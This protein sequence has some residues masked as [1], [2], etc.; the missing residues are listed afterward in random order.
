MEIIVVISIILILFMMILPLWNHLSSKRQNLSCVQ[1]LRALGMAGLS[2]AAENDGALVPY[3]LV[4]PYGDGFWYKILWP[5]LGFTETFHF[6]KV[7]DRKDVGPF[8]CPLNKD[9][10]YA[11]N[12]IC[13]WNNDSPPTANGFKSYL[14]MGQGIVES[15]QDT[16]FGTLYKWQPYILPGSPYETAWFSDGSQ[17]L[18]PDRPAN[19]FFLS[20]HHDGYANVVYM[21]GSVRRVKDPDFAAHPDIIRTSREWTFFFGRPGR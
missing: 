2:F 4:P 20:F 10:I 18:R 15:D 12:R 1:H 21:D 13:G 17:A 16:W 3:A 19:Y 6:S 7:I 14:K 9:T 11:I 5:Y 8:H